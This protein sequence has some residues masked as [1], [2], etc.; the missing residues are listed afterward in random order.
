MTPVEPAHGPGVLLL[1]A[2]AAVAVLLVLILR[3][4]LHAFVA[5]VLVSL[6]TA[7]AT[8]I[9]RADVVAVLLDGFGGTLA[10]VALLVGFGAMLGRML[11]ASGGAQVLA[12]RMIGRFGATRAPLAR[13]YFAISRLPM[14]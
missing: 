4:R 13:S 7:L 11:E 9:P 6:L 3:F 10:T 14:A 8:G 12:D 2:A 1:I 5:L